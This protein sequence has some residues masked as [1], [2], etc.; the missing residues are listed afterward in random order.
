M[1]TERIGGAAPDSS[2]PIDRLSDCQPVCAMGSYFSA[3]CPAADARDARMMG[4]TVCGDV[5]P[6]DGIRV[7]SRRCAGAAD[8]SL[9]QTTETLATEQSDARDLGSGFRS[10]ARQR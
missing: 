2:V 9:A 6:P 8:C 10:R 4:E 5:S 1:A 7:G 3:D